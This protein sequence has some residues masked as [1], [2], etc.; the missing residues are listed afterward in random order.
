MAAQQLEGILGRLLVPDNAVIEQATVEL[1]VFFQNPVDQVV[2]ALVA[3]LSSSPSPQ[4]RQ[5]AAILLRRR[6]VKQWV[7][8][9]PEIHAML[10]QSLLQVLINESET[11]VRQSTSQIV[12]VIA[13]HDLPAGQW[14][15]LFLF[16]N[17][18][19]KSPQSLHREMGM[20]VISSMTE[21]VGEQLR[22]H[23]HSLFHL[24]STT[25]EDQDSYNVLLYT[26]R[27]VT[28]LVAFLGSDEIS[29]LKPLIPKVITVIR[30][31]LSSDEDKACECMDI[32]DELVESEVGIV[33]PHVKSLVEFCLKIA[34]NPDLGDSSRVKALHFINYLIRIKPKIIIKHK[35]LTPILSV[36]FPIMATRGE[37]DAED[38]NEDEE[39]ELSE[40]EASRPCAVA[41]QVV[42]VLALHLPPEKL[43]PPLMQLVEPALSHSNPYHRKAAMISLAVLAEGCADFVRNRHLETILQV[44]CRALS[45]QNIVVRN[46]ALFALGQFA[47]HLQPDIS[48]FSSHILPLLFDYLGQT[49]DNGKGDPSGVTRTY[50]ALETFCENLGEGILPYL[51][52]LM[53]KLLFT[54]TSP[55]SDRIREL[56]I[57]AV[58][59]AANAAGKDMMPYFPKLIDILK[60]YIGNQTFDGSPVQVQS[61]DTVGVLARAIGGENF[62]PISQ[63]WIYIGL[64]LIERQNDP[65]VRRCVYGLFASLSSFL[66]QDM[67]KY[68]QPILKHM[69]NTLQSTEGFVTH[70]NGDEDPSF[71]LDDE[72]ILHEGEIEDD[73]SVTGYS[74]ENAYLEEKE[75]A[76]NSIGEIA[77]N[78]QA[79]FLPFMDEIINEVFKLMQFPHTGVRKGSVTSM[80]QLCRTLYT[81]LNSTSGD[82]TLL[83]G[84]VNNCISTM[85][86]MINEDKD[87]LVVM[88]V[89]SS[90][91]EMLKTMKTDALQEPENLKGLCDAVKNALMS[92]TR[93]QDNDDD[94]IE[95]ETEEQAELDASLVEHA[96]DVLPQLASAVPAHEF[97]AY[98]ASLLPWFLKKMQP[99]SSV[100]DRSFS[101]GTIAETMLSMETSVIPFVPHL[102]PVFLKTLQDEDG[103]VRSNCTYAIGVLAA[104]GGEPIVAHYPA[105]LETLFTLLQREHEVRVVDNIC[106]AV[107]RMIVAN[108]N[109]V[110]IEQVFP[111]LL[112]CLPLKDDFEEN[113]TVYSCIFQLYNSDHPQITQ[114]LVQII[115]I[116]SQV[117]PTST[118]TEETR[119][120]LIQMAQTI[121]QRSPQEFDSVLKTICPEHVSAINE[122]LVRFSQ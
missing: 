82:K 105:I 65:D 54:L 104:Y 37:E 11:I 38:E 50:Y 22:P 10:R 107:C 20:Y 39:E 30:H 95:D 81:L 109:K 60:T 114:N 63:E 78:T 4:A 32:F 73:D 33:I 25:L 122:A 8:L 116:I 14:P 19:I 12:S 67:A 5:F 106:A 99:T 117:L 119:Q 94:D 34:M 112:Q 55:Q 42:D 7:K 101:I 49:V 40:T 31:F 75:D 52:G 108:I 97:V 53:E 76:C 1:R 103:E 87:R 120:I 90:I 100:A 57:S 15:E 84:V 79:A 70:Y 13:K 3:V 115:K 17:Q 2:P 88:A 43:F 48:Q 118:I 68:L 58:G 71:L 93:C 110:P 66:K 92:K 80:S 29:L 35:M 44:V 61:I 28:N 89:L 56:A 27:A 91:E 69:L 98:F 47:E 51:P 18:Y 111:V 36:I 59:A 64:G 121:R 41:A 16:L 113:A 85:I 24:F 26:V 6:V 77:E 74:V 62:Y 86:T 9:S 83:F 72:D 21:T 96:G 45:D 102:Y 46:A 23:F